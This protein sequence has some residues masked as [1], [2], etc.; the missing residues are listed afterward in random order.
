MTN[1]FLNSLT[2]YYIW[3]AVNHNSEN[4]VNKSKAAPANAGKTETKNTLSECLQSNTKTREQDEKR[5]I[6][7]VRQEKNPQKIIE[8]ARIHHSQISSDDVYSVDVKGYKE[9]L[10]AAENPNT[11]TLFLFY[12]YHYPEPI[13]I[14]FSLSDTIIG[15]GS[16]T[17]TAPYVNEE[18]REAVK[19]VLIKREWKLT[20]WEKQNLPNAEINFFEKQLER[21]RLT[22]MLRDTSS[23]T[24]LGEISAEL[25]NLLE[26]R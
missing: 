15:P 18:I 6:E 16:N 2:N 25:I 21:D 13:T 4:M 5:A 20:E 24:P 23:K 11:P 7:E 8:L 3:Q 10:A 26:N 1:S 12:L 22:N 19:T 14:E 17:G 9:K